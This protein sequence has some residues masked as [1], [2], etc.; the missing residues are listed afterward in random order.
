MVTTARPAYTIEAGPAS[1][2]PSLLPRSFSS[3]KQVSRHDS[4]DPANLASDRVA[5]GIRRRD[6]ERRPIGRRGRHR[7]E[8]LRDQGAAGPR[9]ALFR[10]SWTGLGR[11][12]PSAARFAR[13]LAR[14]R[15]SRAGRQARRSEAEPAHQ[16]DQPRR[17]RADAPQ[18]Q[19]AS[20]RNR[21]SNR[22]GRARR[23]VASQRTAVA[24][25]GGGVRGTASAASI[26]RNFWAFQ[27]PREPAIPS[28]ELHELANEPDRSLRA[29]RA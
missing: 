7:R 13:G 27:P 26:D 29:A 18:D 9:G 16:R 10:V 12:R 23:P 8:I 17:R 28:V 11:R 3:G 21:R 5:R 22:L 4:S 14:R 19:T 24:G 1:S 20:R 25:K 15:R 2:H 6:V